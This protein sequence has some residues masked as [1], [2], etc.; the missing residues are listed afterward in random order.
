MS[1]HE[2]QTG[3]SEIL[4]MMGAATFVVAIRVAAPEEIPVDLVIAL[5]VVRPFMH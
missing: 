3:G 4:V 1:L 5:R 2:R